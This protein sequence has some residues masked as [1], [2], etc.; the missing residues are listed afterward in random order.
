[1]PSKPIPGSTGDVLTC[2]PS[3]YLPHAPTG[4]LYLPRFLAKCRYV[5]EHGKLPPSYAKNYKR[6]IDRF[7]CLHLGID[8]NAV[9]RIVHECIDAGLDDAERDRRLAQI[10]PADVRAAHWN[11]ELVQKGMTPAGREFLRDALTAMGCADR[12]DD[13]KSVPDLIDFDE[14]RIE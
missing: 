9:E 1:M 14:G 10:F 8:P 13:I 7:L 3:P 2:L 11:R 4:L 6:G 5:K 12:V